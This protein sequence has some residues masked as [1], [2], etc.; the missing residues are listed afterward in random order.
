[1]S[2]SQ[3]QK[4]STVVKE[5]LNNIALQISAIQDQIDSLA[6]VILQNRRGLDL[7][8]AEKGRLRLLGKDCFFTNKSG[9]ETE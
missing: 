7:L 5:S 1:V 9:I 8:T 6:V 3:F 4:V 2:I